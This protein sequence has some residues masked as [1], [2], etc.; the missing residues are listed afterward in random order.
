MDGVAVGREQWRPWAVLGVVLV[1]AGWLSSEVLRVEDPTGG[2]QAHATTAWLGAGT[3]EAA[4]ELAREVFD[5][6]NSERRAR[7]LHHLVWDDEL[8]ATAGRWSAQM[9]TDGYEHSTA[10]FRATARYPTS[11]ENIAY[12][13]RDTRELHVGWMRSDGHRASILSPHVTAAGVGIVCRS[14]GSMWATQIFGVPA[15]DL[16][17]APAPPAGWQRDQPVEPLVATGRG[18]R[19]AAG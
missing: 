13:L 10:E 5:R 16:P 1:A 8:A 3:P 19:C 4:E 11:G 9:V 18:L 7:G 15:P 2:A 17:P 12:G 14:D 6:V